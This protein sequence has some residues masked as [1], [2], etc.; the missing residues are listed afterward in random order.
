MPRTSEVVPFPSPHLDKQRLA[1]LI[2]AGYDPANKRMIKA[3][4]GKYYVKQQVPI[5]DR[6]LLEHVIDAALGAERVAQVYVVGDAQFVDTLIEKQPKF[7]KGRI[8]AEPQE[9]SSPDGKRKANLI[10]NLKHGIEQCIEPYNSD[11]QEKG[12]VLD[13]RVL[14]LTSDTPFIS[15]RDIDKFINEA[16]KADVVMSATDGDAYVQMVEKLG[17]SIDPAMTKIAMF[18]IGTRMVRPNNMFLLRY[19]KLTPELYQLFQNIYDARY[20][21]DWAGGLKVRKILKL[22]R[23]ENRIIQEYGRSIGAEFTVRRGVANEYGMIAAFC[24]SYIVNRINDKIRGKIGVPLIPNIPRYTMVS[25][26][27]FRTVARQLLGN[28]VSMELYVSGLVG[29]M[30]DLDVQAMYDLLA[31]DDF[32]NFKRIRAYLD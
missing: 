12:A 20:V 15:G 21:V 16:S 11:R 1:C 9:E 5:H 23:E 30:L 17:I 32:K 3:V 25:R 28:R 31:K 6:P 13:D 24:L 19:Q 22:L 26:R 14:I 29:P 18:P 10:D 2:M 7:Q 8:F 4:D 27:D